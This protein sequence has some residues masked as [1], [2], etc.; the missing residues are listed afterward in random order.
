[1][2]ADRTAHSLFLSYSSKHRDLARELAGT[3]E[4][5]YGAGSVWWDHALES[6]GDYEVQIRNALEQAGV[7]VV[8]WSASAAA[9]DWVKSEAGRANRGHKL[10]N[11]RTPD[12][13]WRDIPSPYDQHHV[14]ELPDTPGILRSIDAV[15]SGKTVRTAVPLH[16]IYFRHHGQRLIDPKQRTLPRNPRDIG[17]SELLQAPYEV[18]GY[19]DVSDVQTRFFE[20]GTQPGRAAAGRLIYGPGG[21]GKTRLMVSLAA[22]LRGRGW[23][24]G[25]LDRPRDSSEPALKQR[26]QA[27]EQLIQEGEGDGD[28]RGL[29]I[30]VDYAEARQDEVRALARCFCERADAETRP[31]RLVL[32]ARSAAEWWTTLHDETPEIQ[33]VFRGDEAASAIELPAVASGALRL[34]L[35]EKS[36]EAF[37]PWGAAQ[38]VTEPSAPSKTYLTQLETD[39]EFGRPLAIQMAALVWL[40]SARSAA[41]ATSVEELLRRVLGLER[42]HWRKI[43]GGLDDEDRRDLARAVA[44]V[45]L[46]GGTLT[47]ESV[48][49]LL[50]ADDFYRGRRTARVDVDRVRRQLSSL[51][52]GPNGVIVPLEPDLL[53]EHHV[54]SVGDKE[55]VDGCVQWAEGEPPEDREQ[56]RRYVLIVLQRAAQFEHGPH[57]GP[58][59]IA[60]L[61]HLVEKH[62]VAVAAGIVAVA[63]NEPGALASVL[64]RTVDRLAPEAVIALDRALPE[65]SVALLDVSLKIAGRR[66]GVARDALALVSGEAKARAAGLERNLAASLDNL[67]IRLSSLGRLEEALVTSQ[68]A[69]MIYRRL[70]DARADDAFLPDL[71]R[72]LH[73]LGARLSNVG[74][75]E[76]ALTATQEAVAIYRRL[77]RERADDFLPDLAKCLNNIGIL[78]SN[79]GRHETAL[80]ATRESVAIRRLLSQAHGD[81]FLPGL[82]HSL[83]NLGVRLSALGRYEQA[84][85]ACQEAVA[86]YRQLVD[87]HP[88]AFMAD[89]STG[90]DNLGL[91]LSLLGRHEEALAANEEGVAILRRLVEA[92]PDAFLPRLSNSLNNLSLQL[93]NLG[94]HEEALAPSQAAV[95][96]VSRQSEAHPEAFLPDLARSIGAQSHIFAALGRHAEAARA[97]H[98]A[99]EVIAPFVERHSAAFGR[100]AS[101]ILN[102]LLKYSEAS[103]EIP[104]LTL[105][106]RV[107][108]ALGDASPSEPE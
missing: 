8:L 70:A 106:E 55:L 31:V 5:Q 73:N 82:S 104:D 84:L 98:Q 40:T 59:A 96:I 33:R 79:L 21:L 64:G 34:A 76:A 12:T 48:E 50:M 3:L 2:P 102:D 57:V 89:L 17:P 47:L 74:Q 43:L 10:V 35:F 53:A 86:I 23:T 15:W 56:R 28:D 29:L 107:Q 30:V 20:W 60:L 80:A 105:I 41:D 90:L 67:S 78:L 65:Q 77:A 100:L 44:Q 22:R 72:G 24:A 91:Q 66:V 51:Y 87:A 36:V 14:S 101:A 9:S 81:A 16:E 32:L 46:V 18:V 25:F 45:A 103:S 19:I 52:S 68:E 54:A 13:S 94:R 88:D 6:W 97:A 1:M 69:V 62:A 4:A 11:V 42:D 99:L 63:V 92:R 108:Q 85:A 61:E 93:S 7:V 71:A 37:R 38:S 75:R 49:R 95:A 39:P 26:W 27:I 58:Q 83:H